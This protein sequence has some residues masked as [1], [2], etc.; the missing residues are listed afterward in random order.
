[1]VAA[2]V[3]VRDPSRFSLPVSLGILLPVA[4]A[5]SHILW[6][7]RG[8]NS[9]KGVALAATWGSFMLLAS[10]VLATAPVLLSLYGV[11]P[12]LL[13][14]RAWPLFIGSLVFVLIQVWLVAAAI[15]AYDLMERQPGAERVLVRSVLTATGY[16]ASFLLLAVALPAI[17]K[18]DIA[19]N[20]RVAYTYLYH[21]N[22]YI[23]I[24]SDTYKNGFPPL[25]DV[26]GAP[27]V[28]G[29]PDC[30]HANIVNPSFFFGEIS[31][32]RIE[33]IPGSPVENPGPGCRVPGVKTYSVHARPV[34][35]GETG[36]RSYYSDQDGRI[37]HTSSDR[38]ATARDAYP[39]Y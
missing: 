25:L 22:S 39:I 7:S 34:R 20:E 30:N 33:Y 15:C 13:N 5:Y 35:Y 26:L 36:Y 4:L 18:S 29:A 14:P 11:P 27:P 16:L 2:L 24:Y 28:G 23:R 1:M 31:G 12:P 10:L 17:N 32:Y 38:P 21:I 37:H 6:R 3:L 9:R 8:P 19:P